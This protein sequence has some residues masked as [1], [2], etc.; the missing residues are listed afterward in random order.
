MNKTQPPAA[1][2][3]RPLPAGRRPKDGEACNTIKAHCV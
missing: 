3:T 2:G 1:T